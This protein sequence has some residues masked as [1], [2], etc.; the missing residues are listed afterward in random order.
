[1][2]MIDDDNMELE[3][4][5][6]EGTVFVPEKKKMN[7]LMGM[8]L[9]L[10]GIFLLIGLSSIATLLYMIRTFIM[11]FLSMLTGWDPIISSIF[12]GV[13][14]LFIATLLYII[15]RRGSDIIQKV[16]AILKSNV[17]NEPTEYYALD[18]I[19]TEE[20]LHELKKNRG[21]DVL[22]KESGGITI[23]C[24][25]MALTRRIKAVT[26]QDVY[27]LS[28]MQKWAIIT[29]VTL[30]WGI[31][32]GI[33]MFEIIEQDYLWIGAV[34][35]LS[36][37]AFFLLG[38][39]IIKLWHIIILWVGVNIYL[40]LFSKTDPIIMWSIWGALA[41]FIVLVAIFYLLYESAC[42]LEKKWYCE[43]M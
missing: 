9:I 19:E 21:C 37:S 2:I 16:E 35:V 1:M 13:F 32:L 24:S 33:V 20:I 29:V 5:Y 31:Y 7:F 40:S 12:I 10:A 6:E 27:T 15:A 17:T 4:V 18:I 25:S 14:A 30:I 11:D 43:I 8:L 34:I 28:N 41:I 36:I 42:N 23:E 38:G 3:R 26:D 22:E 39:K